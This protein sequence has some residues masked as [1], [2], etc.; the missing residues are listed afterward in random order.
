VA[1]RQ[2]LKRLILEVLGDPGV[3]RRLAE[4]VTE[5]VAAERGLG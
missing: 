5:A 3:A 2:E 1:E 4:L